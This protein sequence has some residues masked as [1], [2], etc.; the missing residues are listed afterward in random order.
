MSAL[1]RLLLDRIIVTA[2]A[3]VWVGG[4]VPGFGAV[5]GGVEEQG[6]GLFSDH[7]TLIAPAGPAFSIWSLVYAGLAGYVVWQWLPATRTSTWA[8]VTRRPAAAAIALNGA[9]LL[10]VFAGWL[11]VSVVVMVG[12][13]VSLR[14]V[15]RATSGLPR[16]GWPTRLLVSST[17]GLYLGWIC[18]AT[19]ANIASALVGAGIPPTGP[20]AAWTTVVVLALVVLVAARL[21]RRTGHRWFRG[22]LAAAI[23]WGTAWIAVGRLTGELRSDLVGAAAALTAV[24]VAALGLWSLHVGAGRGAGRGSDPG[25]DP[26]SDLRGAVTA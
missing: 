19:C 6:G 25:N 5:G 11:W 9:W 21:L 16:G 4:T 17:F 18:V 24:V 8:R 10:V 2:A 22:P 14:L 13:V 15:L 7:A 20:A 12:I 1:D 23:V 3:A 26:D